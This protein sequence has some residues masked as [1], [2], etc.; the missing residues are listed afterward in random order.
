MKTFN[1]VVAENEEFDFKGILATES[2]DHF[3]PGTGLTLAHDILEHVASHPP[4]PYAD[5]FMALGAMVAVRAEQGYHS[6]SRY[7]KLKD[8]ANEVSILVQSMYWQGKTLTEPTT[9]PQGH[10][11]WL[12]VLSHTEE[13]INN[14][15]E[16]EDDENIIT[17]ESL[18]ENIT[19]WII[20][21]YKNCLDHYQGLDLY[22]ICK[23]FK[24]IADQ[25]DKWL[26]DAEIGATATLTLDFET[27]RATLEEYWDWEG[28]ELTEDY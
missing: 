5:E 16:E 24:D 26:K 12:E 3:E 13:G 17:T 2:P 14:F 1:L 10:D 19:A 22:N 21:G 25:G 18:A 8:V 27:G 15:L 6:G 4:D 11:L 7:I 9:L 28:I 20:K 23:L